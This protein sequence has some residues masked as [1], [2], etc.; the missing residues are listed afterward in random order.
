MP[1]S[2]AADARRALRMQTRSNTAR[3]STTAP[4]TPTAAQKS[5]ATPRNT[6]AAA[7][8]SAMKISP[9]TY[10]STP[11]PLRNYLVDPASKVAYLVVK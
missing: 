6:S 5:G 11:S 1:P 7:Q 2:N 4:V 3:E 9:T 8:V 10:L